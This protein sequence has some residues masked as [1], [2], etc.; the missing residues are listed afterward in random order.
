MANVIIWLCRMQ[1]T[2]FL[3]HI[4]FYLIFLNLLLLESQAN[5]ADLRSLY[6]DSD[7]G[8]LLDFFLFN[9]FYFGT[10]RFKILNCSSIVY[11]HVR[12]CAILYDYVRSRSSVTWSQ[13]QNHFL[14]Q[15]TCA[16]AF[17]LVGS[18]VNT[19]F[20]ANKISSSWSIGGH[21]RWLHTS[22]IYEYR[23]N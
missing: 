22:C 9:F 10:F 19:I 12:S 8:K 18:Y 11:D 15:S 17:D 6:C 1:V 3:A 2:L 4:L 16:I 13:K 14:F 20:T 5:N 21:V 7:F 23:W